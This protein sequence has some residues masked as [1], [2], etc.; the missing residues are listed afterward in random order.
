[1]IEGTIIVDNGDSAI[2]FIGEITYD[3]M[4]DNPKM[5]Y[6]HIKETDIDKAFL[7]K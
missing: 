2:D 6:K 5:L 4:S 3:I 7:S 1:M